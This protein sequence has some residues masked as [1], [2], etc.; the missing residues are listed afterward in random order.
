LH[1]DDDELSS[2]SVLSNIRKIFISKKIGYL[3]LKYYYKT[4]TGRVFD[5]FTF[6][7]IQNHIPPNLSYIKIVFYIYKT[8]F[9]FLTGVIFKNENIKKLGYMENNQKNLQMDGFF[10]DYLIPL[11]K[12]YGAAIDYQNYVI[13]MWSANK[14]NVHYYD[15]LNN[16]CSYEKAWQIVYKYLNQK[17]KKRWIETETY[18]ATF[19][20]PSLKYYSSNS[21]LV[22]TTKRLMQL[23]KKLIRYPVFWIF[24]V[25]AF[26]MPN[27][28]WDI[29]RQ[30][31]LYF[32]QT[33]IL[34]KKK[35]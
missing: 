18:L 17:E 7:K 6:K 24:N 26:L 2:L 29:I 12:K 10:I 8:Y 21:N 14:K 25:I 13:A 35:N 31:V 19:N 32:K 5:Y 9:Q 33:N 30:V 11:T 34:E 1:G 3:R 20:L 4:N 16:E 15:C 27:R 28:L 23:N 22:A